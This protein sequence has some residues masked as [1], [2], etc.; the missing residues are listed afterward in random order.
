MLAP[1]PCKRIIFGSDGLGKPQLKVFYEEKK[2]F[3]EVPTTWLPGND[4]GTTTSASKELKN[5]FGKKIFDYPKPVELIKYL[6]HLAT[7]D[8]DIVLDSF[9]GSGS[10]AQAVLEQNQ[11]NLQLRNYL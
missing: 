7:K 2:I 8:G 11:K 1:N 10:T 9:A 5:I 4:Y 3:G 6:L